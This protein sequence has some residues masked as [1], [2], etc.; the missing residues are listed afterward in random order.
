LERG[1]T[2]EKNPLSVP[3]HWALP[4]LVC[5]CLAHTPSVGEHPARTYGSFPFRETTRCAWAES[6]TTCGTVV[7]KAHTD[8]PRKIDCAVAAIVAHDRAACTPRT[9]WPPKHRGGDLETVASPQVDDQA[10]AVGVA[11]ERKMPP[12]PTDA[13][14]GSSGSQGSGR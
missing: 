5:N 6:D 9:A 10:P 7:T 3:A 12:R 4:I 1:V 8:S 13:R 11:P 2:V 14:S